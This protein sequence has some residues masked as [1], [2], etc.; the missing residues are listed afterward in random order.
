MKKKFLILPVA[1]M[2]SLVLSGCSVSLSIGGPSS[3]SDVIEKYNA[4][5]EESLNYHTDMDL[6]FN[7]SAKAE[8]LSIELPI[9]MG[10]SADV[11]DDN[12]HGDM[13]LSMSLM[14]ESME[15]FT[16]IYV[17][18]RRKVN[19]YTYDSDS[20]QWIISKEKGGTEL[21]C[22]FNDIDP[23]DFKTAEMEKDKRSDT[24]V[25]T[26]SFADFAE[27][28]SMYDALED[29]YDDMA[30]MM[31]M[32]ADDFLDEWKD[33]KVIYV[34]DKDYYLTSVSVEGCEY[35]GKI[36]E[37]GTSIDVSVSL[38]LAFAFSD[39]GKI[40]ESDV[41]VPDKV[42]DAAVP[43]PQIDDIDEYDITDTENITM[44]PEEIDPGFVKEPEENTDPKFVMT[45][46]DEEI[47]PGFSVSPVTQND[48]PKTS[49]D[50]YGSYNG[51]PLAGIGDDWNTTF[52]ADGW[53]FDNVDGEFSFMSAVNSKYEDA[54]L[55]VYN[56]KRANT[57]SADILNNGIY[58]Y[59]IDC[60]FA[61]IY[62]PMTWNGITFGA[63]AEDI[64]KAYGSPDF[65]YE[66]SMYTSYEYSMYG[67][68]EIEFYVYPDDGL[69]RVN[70]SYY[71]GL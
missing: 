71:G 39:Y 31:D 14:G 63:S 25:I 53:R 51:I 22:G 45:A 64:I 52:G 47:D 55:Y 57:A 56:R 36:S 17:D 10:L 50:K 29:T 15:E 26:Q 70:V 28:G 7:I 59:D 68:M 8:G 18:G 27:N 69:K 43:A 61:S 65:T 23:E 3:A 35:S 2:A 21:A 4:L 33:A 19:V 9:S 62:P 12:L 30:D 11:L 41:E 60:S 42:K 32:D 44:T 20:G 1:A 37:D 66:G 16:E 38:E 6:N 13:N 54:T 24:Y 49:D 34:F 40:R 67:S 48:K 58:G 5:M 46:P